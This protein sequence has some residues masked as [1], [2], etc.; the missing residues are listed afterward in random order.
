VR[1]LVTRPQPEADATASRLRARGHEPL[2]APLLAIRPVEGLEPGAAIWSGALVTSANALRV[3]S[4]P[5]VEALR[6]L[7]LLAVGRRTAEAARAAGF[8]AVE[9][10]DGDAA[11]LARLAAARF[12][13]APHPVLYLA[14]AERARDLEA[15]LTPAGI[16]VRTVVVYRMAPARAF[17]TTVHAALVSGSIAGVLHYSRRAAAVD[18]ACAESGGIEA[19]AL[20]PTHYCLSEAVAA[21]FRASGAAVRVAERP[22]EESLLDLIPR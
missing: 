3:L 1:L 11:D 5:Q 12:A 8:A 22:N 2:V 21:D 17:P 20:A 9:S 19:A 16:A 4:A 15:A 18:R 7:P 10:A 14:G 6:D 13:D